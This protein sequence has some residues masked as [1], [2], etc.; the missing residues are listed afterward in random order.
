MSFKV[1]RGRWCTIWVPGFVWL[2]SDLTVPQRENMK[3]EG[4]RERSN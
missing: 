4:E 2:A 3:R 1:L